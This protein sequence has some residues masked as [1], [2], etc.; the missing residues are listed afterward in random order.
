MESARVVVIGG[1]NMGAAVLYH[2]AKE[3]WKDI[4]LVEKAELTSGATWHAAGLVSRMTPGHA[5]GTCHDYAVDLYKTIE[6]ETEQGVSWHNCGSLRVGATEDHREWLM[7]TRDA[8][9][10]RGQDCH[11]VTPAEIAEL[12]PIYDTSHIIGGIYTPDD[13]HVDP[14][15]TCQ[16]MAKGARMRGARVMRRNRVTDVVQQ[17]S[18]EWLVRTE[19]GDI[20]C[21]HVVNAGGYHARQ[22]GAFSGLDLPIVPMQ[23]HY[24]VTDTVPE[25]ETMGHEIPVTRDDY[26]TGYLRREQGGALIGLYDTHDALAKWREGCP[27]DSE[28]ELFEPDYDRIIPWLEKCF[29]RYPSLME[30]GI[31]R[32]V[33]GAITYTPDGHPLVGPA[34]GLR[35]YWLACGA[36]V[37]I[38]WGPGL[39]RALAQW[40]VHG[41]AD[42]SMRGFDPRRFGDWVDEDHAYQRCRENYMTRL[43]L[44]YPQIQYE[45]CRDVRISGAHDR[46]KALGAVYEDA[47]GWE[48][49]RVYGKDW[50]GV[51]PKAWRRGPSWEAAVKEAQAVHA[52]V[53]LGDFTAFSKFEITGPEAEAYLNRLCANRM[54]RAV[55]G[56]CLTLLLNE[57][58]TIEGEA[59]IARL[60]EDRFWFVT[61]GPSERRVWD[62]ITLHQRGSEDVTVRNLSDDWGILTIAGPKARDVLATQTDASLE[63]ADFGWLKAREITV[64]GVPL[65][66]MRMSFSGELA[67][68]LHAPNA[69]LGTLWDALWEAG[70]P[71]NITPFGS[72]ALEM[73]RMEKAYR[74]GHELANDASPVHTDQMRFVKL[75]KPFVGR[76]AVARRVETGEASVIVYLDVDVFDS[77][78]LGGEAVYLNGE[79]V[80]SISSGGYGPNT[81]RSLAF[82]F[83]KPDAAKPGTALEISLFGDRHNATVLAEPVLDPQNER[84]KA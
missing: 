12:N 42:I 67:W 44:P 41:T 45:T 16:A 25:F 83:L 70:Q 11:W 55:G 29:E 57:Q 22:I 3:G 39:G 24:V 53:G 32:I 28:N 59:T 52:G 14:S 58:G 65:I 36:T 51:E 47:G 48:R 33:N 49:P 30:L 75:D 8:V 62:W 71:H 66:A 54:P 40:M 79:K 35:N 81:G 6:Q 78:V 34:P 37:G 56:T 76:D 64:A 5:L 10:A 31:K 13:G 74:G 27:W 2:L 82:A 23:H 18:G 1:G 20:L 15:G 17:P 26:F 50:G 38:A 19:Q 72:K 9:L 21:E 63:N 68:E 73:M 61:G 7:H 43:S 84:L 77:D 69:Q 46:T 60:A 4:V 80:G